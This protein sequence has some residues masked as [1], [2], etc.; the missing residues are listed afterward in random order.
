MYVSKNCPDCDKAKAL[1]KEN[2]IQFEA[3]EISAA[4]V[5]FKGKFT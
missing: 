5:T 1:L 2:N 3:T 4:E